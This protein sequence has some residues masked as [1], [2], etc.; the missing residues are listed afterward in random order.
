MSKR[1]GEEFLLTSIAARS[2]ENVPTPT[3]E[4]CSFP[5]P[6]PPLHSFS[7]WP[8]PHLPSPSTLVTM[9]V[10]RSRNVYMQCAQPDYQVTN[11]V[12]SAWIVGYDCNT[13]LNSAIFYLGL[14]KQIYST[15]TS[16]VFLR[17]AIMVSSTRAYLSCPLTACFSQ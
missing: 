5:F 1:R 4:Q 11:A 7:L 8:A 13:R 10:Q 14:E 12:I 3:P 17:K 15:I 6:A 16:S 2:Y 9:R